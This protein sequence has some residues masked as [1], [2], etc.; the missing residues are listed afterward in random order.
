MTRAARPYSTTALA[1]L[2]E[3]DETVESRP[4]DAPSGLFTVE[5]T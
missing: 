1:L 3:A 5:A 2:D 4:H